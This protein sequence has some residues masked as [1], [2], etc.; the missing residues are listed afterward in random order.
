MNSACLPVYYT[1]TPKSL[2]TDFK[3]L[4][5]AITDIH[6]GRTAGIYTR[7]PSVLLHNLFVQIALEGLILNVDI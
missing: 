2:C 7:C 1:F 6:A 3:F 4:L 5:T